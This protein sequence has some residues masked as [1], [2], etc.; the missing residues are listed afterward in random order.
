MGRIPNMFLSKDPN[1]VS[2]EG[3]LRWFLIIIW[4]CTSTRALGRAIVG[5][6]GKPKGRH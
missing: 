2:L 4:P 6:C 3:P 5:Q 1:L